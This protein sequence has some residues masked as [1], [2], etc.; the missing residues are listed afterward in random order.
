MGGVVIGDQQSPLGSQ[1]AQFPPHGVLDPDLAAQQCPRGLVE[2]G[3]AGLAEHGTAADHPV[4]SEQW[5]V[6]ED[7]CSEVVSLDECLFQAVVDRLGREPGVMLVTRESL[8]VGGGDDVAAVDQ[9]G[10]RVV[11]QAGDAQHV[12]RVHRRPPAATGGSSSMRATAGV[13]ESARARCPAGV[14]WMSFANR[15]ARRSAG[16]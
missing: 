7:D 6:V 12:G 11:I 15:K 3:G 5:R 4:Q 13:N 9:R 16:G 8:L 1:G 10:R 14:G 2:A